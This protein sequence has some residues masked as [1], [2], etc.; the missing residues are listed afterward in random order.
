MKKTILIIGFMLVYSSVF[1]Q[2]LVDGLKWNNTSGGTDD[3]GINLYRNFTYKV[4]GDTTINGIDYK[5]IKKNYPDVDNQWSSAFYLREENRKWYLIGRNGN[6]NVEEELLYDFSL[7]TGDSINLPWAYNIYVNVVADGDTILEN[8]ESRKY[9]ILGNNDVPTNCNDI[10]IEGLGSAICHIDV[11]CF[12]L[13]SV[14]ACATSLCA[15]FNNEL[16]FTSYPN[17]HCYDTGGNFITSL[18]DIFSKDNSITIY[19]NPASKEVNISSES[20]INSIEVFNSL[21]QKV[22]QTNIKAKEKTLDINSLSKGVYIIGVSTD[23]G[24][25]R[26]KL[27]KA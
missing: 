12:Y 21:G 2:Y 15:S 26:K 20:I 11:P 7:M 8:G 22:Y 18:T 27:V 19:P 17:L 14:D 23:K 25:V 6:L 24:Y 9:L 1:S 4:D 10:W 13:I 16:L 3:W 5:I